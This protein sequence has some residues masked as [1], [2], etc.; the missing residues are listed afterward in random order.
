MYGLQLLSQ[1]TNAAL[2]LMTD[3]THLLKVC[4][5]VLHFTMN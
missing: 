4:N 5:S 3:Q 2:S 1:A